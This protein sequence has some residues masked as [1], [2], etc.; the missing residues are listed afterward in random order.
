MN[1]IFGLA[2]AAVVFLLIDLYVW[3]AVKLLIRSSGGLTQRIVGYGYWG[4][5][6]VSII[7]FLGV[8]TYMPSAPPVKASARTFLMA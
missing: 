3:Q 7:T 1:R 4:L 6:I 2:L 8:F 5:T